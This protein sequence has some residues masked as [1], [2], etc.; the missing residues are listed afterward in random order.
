MEFYRFISYGGIY[1]QKYWGNV[2]VMTFFMIC[3]FNFG[4]VGG[5]RGDNDQ[6]NRVDIK[7]VLLM[8]KLT[9]G[10]LSRGIWFTFGRGHF[11]S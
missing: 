7:L 6:G 1:T 4:P 5:V 10:S 11:W 8:D 2:F 9:M 3:T